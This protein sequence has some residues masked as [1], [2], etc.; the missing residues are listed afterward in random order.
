MGIKSIKMKV[1]AR[2]LKK[3]RRKGSFSQKKKCRFKSSPDQ[4]KLIDYKNAD[5]LK[6]FL[7]ERGK[8]LPSRIS[9]VSARYQRMLADEIKKARIMALLPYGTLQPY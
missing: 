7:T 8:I 1:S 9:G 2:L 6:K 3:K 4:V 5:F